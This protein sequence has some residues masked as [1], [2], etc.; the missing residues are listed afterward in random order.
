MPIPPHPRARV[1]GAGSRSSPCLILPWRG[2]AGGQGGTGRP[3]LPTP[4]VIDRTSGERQVP[5]QPPFAYLIIDD[6][7]CLYSA[8]LSVQVTEMER[9]HPSLGGDAASQGMRTASPQPAVASWGLP[10]RGPPASLD[11]RRRRAPRPSNGKLG[12]FP[13]FM[14]SVAASPP[15]YPSG[16]SYTSK[17]LSLPL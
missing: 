2:W 10:P 16:I 12:A 4:L 6:L 17:M 14:D 15:L 11:P 1:E 7:I 8:S 5:P 13:S 3:S 9:P